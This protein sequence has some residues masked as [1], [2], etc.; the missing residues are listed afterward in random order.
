NFIEFKADGVVVNPLRIRPEI[1]NELSTHLVLCNTGRTRLSS[2]ILR[3]QIKSYESGDK[4]I[5]RNLEGLKRLASKLKDSLLK[6]QVEKVGQSTKW[7]E[8]SLS[9]SGL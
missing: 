2:R 5:L 3:R 7:V 4:R 8:S 1:L 6:G 9:I